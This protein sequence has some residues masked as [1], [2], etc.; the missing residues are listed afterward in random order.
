LKADVTLE[1]E[2]GRKLFPPREAGLI[3]GIVA[4][5]L[6]YYDASIAPETISQLNE[7]CRERELLRKSHRFEKY[8]IST[9]AIRRAILA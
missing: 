6:P 8:L 5:D 9:E 4:R 1:T 3:A 2:V 7:F